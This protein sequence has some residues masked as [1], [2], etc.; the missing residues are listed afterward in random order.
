MHCKKSQSATEF[1]ILIAAL[2]AV[3]LPIFYLLSDYGLKSG[4]E[5]L[6]SQIN[7]IGTKIVDESREIYYLGLYS[8]EVIT[9][10]LPENIIRMNSLVIDSGGA[11]E[12]YFL[13]HFRKDKYVLN[14][15]FPSEV[16]IITDDCHSYSCFGGDTCHVCNIRTHSEAAGVRNLRLE[17]TLWDAGMGVNVTQVQI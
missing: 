2:L 9:I 4:S 16:P 5:L 6:S 17:S 1:A 14:A 8:K 3:F 7:Q 10:N 11:T 15:S 13:I 12:T